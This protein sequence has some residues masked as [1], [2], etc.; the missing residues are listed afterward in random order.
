MIPI[1]P[2]ASGE[3]IVA[4]PVRPVQ[5][6][7][8]I[9]SGPGNPQPALSSQPARLPQTGS[10]APIASSRRAAQPTPAAPKQPAAPAA[11]PVQYQEELP[12]PDSYP[13]VIRSTPKNVD[14]EPKLSAPPR[15]VPGRVVRQQPGVIPMPPMGSMVDDTICPEPGSLKK[16]VE[17]DDKIAPEGDIFPQ[18]CKLG[19]EMFAGRSFC[20]LTYTW[21]ASALCHKPLY[22]EE[23][24]L[25]RYGQVRFPLLQPAISGAKFVGS[26]PVLP[27]KM[28]LEPPDECMYVLGYYRPGSCAPYLRERIPVQADAIALQAAFVGGIIWLIP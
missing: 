24:Y 26:I 20:P 13:K 4:R 10:A 8:R 17:I 21:K 25:E 22:F 19:D 3:R 28:G 16:L 2:P 6:M 7:Q 23:I 9:P 1:A 5:T 18:E 27:Y 12:A 14:T 11:T 15:S